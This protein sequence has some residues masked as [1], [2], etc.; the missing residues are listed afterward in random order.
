MLGPRGSASRAS[1]WRDELRNID[2]PDPVYEGTRMCEHGET[3][4]SALHHLFYR[5]TTLPCYRVLVLPMVD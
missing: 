3:G 2:I 5:R 4:L 1:T